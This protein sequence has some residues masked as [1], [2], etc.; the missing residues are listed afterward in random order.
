M[1]PPC[2]RSWRTSAAECSSITACPAFD[3]AAAAALATLAVASPAALATLAVASPAALATLAVASPAA[4]ATLVD[5]SA[6]SSTCAALATACPTLD[7]AAAASDAGCESSACSPTPAASLLKPTAFFFRSTPFSSAACTTC[8]NHSTR[9][10]TRCK[11]GGD[12]RRSLSRS[13]R[14][15]GEAS[16]QCYAPRGLRRVRPEGS[17]VALYCATLDAFRAM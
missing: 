10:Q 4:L 13:A 12:R 8:I 16:F 9:A 17:N 14:L 5:A 7:V 6:M 15:G 11:G 3:V 2:N 1:Q